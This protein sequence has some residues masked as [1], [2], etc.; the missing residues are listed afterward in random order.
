MKLKSLCHKTGYKEINIGLDILDNDQ[1]LIFRNEI[2]A[3]DPEKILEIIESTSVFSSEEVNIAIELADERLKKGD[4]SDYHFL[5]GERYGKMVGYS[6]FGKIAG[7][8]S[9]F[10]LYWLAVHRDLHNLGIGKAL[11]TKSESIISEMKG[12]RIYIE[13]SSRKSYEAARLFYSHCGYKKEA[14]LKDFYS[15]G[16]NKVIYVKEIRSR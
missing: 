15:A 14:I 11:L 8:I 9:S 1:E 4:Q 16:D 5:F 10:D 7:T 3:D 6:C 13:T 2:T 12:D